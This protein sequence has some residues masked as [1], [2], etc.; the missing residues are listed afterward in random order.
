MWHS[1]ELDSS[2]GSRARL[3]GN[4]PEGCNRGPVLDPLRDVTLGDPV[5]AHQKVVA[6]EGLHLLFSESLRRS[7]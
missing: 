5:I 3:R 4:G 2:S 7:R 1:T 6:V